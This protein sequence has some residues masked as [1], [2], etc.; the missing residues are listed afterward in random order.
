MASLYPHKTLWINHRE[1]T[2]EAIC[3]QLEQPRDAFEEHTF[4][5]IREWFSDVSF[6]TLHTS[7]STGSPKPI[8]LTRDQLETS[9]RFTLDALKINA[10]Q[11]SN[12]LVCLDTRF[13]AGRMM[14]VRSFIA[15]LIIHAITPA[16]KIIEQLDDLRFELS[17]WVPMQVYEAL[18]SPY[19]HRLNNIHHLLIGGAPLD[20]EAQQQLTGY[21]CNAYLTYG[22]TETISHVALQQIQKNSSNVFRALP[23]IHFE[24]DDRGCLIIHAPHF[25]DPIHTNDLI[26]LIS[27]TD[28]EWLGRWDNVIN[29]GGIK[30]IPETIEQ[31]IANLLIENGFSGAYFVAGLPHPTKGHEVTLFLEGKSQQEN[32]EGIK[33]ALRNSLEGYEAPRKIMWL[34]TFIRTEN[35][36]LN[37]LETFKKYLNHS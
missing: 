15:G 8:L 17:A 5:F 20:L 29:S 23:K 19:A 2:L 4:E 24:Q 18:K 1:V 11:N 21:T 27:S 33:E 31:K 36:K 25:S 12:A 3:H 30:I 35:G 26:R 28:F 34:D 10:S 22:M 32:V 9:A 14:L 16:S 7:G 6:F 13:I 37:R